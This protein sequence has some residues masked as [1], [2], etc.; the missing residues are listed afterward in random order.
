MPGLFSSLLGGLGANSPSPAGGLGGG[1]LFGMDREA[2]GM[3]GAGMMNRNMAGGMM[4]A[5]KFQ[6]M[7]RQQNMTAKL[8]LNRGIA[9][10]EE[11]ALAMAQQPALINALKGDTNA[12]AERAEAA[13]QYGLTG[14]EATSFVL[15]GQLPS[16]RFGSAEVGLSPIWGQDAEG[17]YVL[18]QPSKS[19]DMVPSRMPDGVKPLSPYDKSFQTSSGQVAGKG[20]GEALSEWRSMSSKMPSVEQVVR[21]LDALA[22]K[23]TYTYLGQGRDWL[24]RQSGY[25]ATEGATAR[26]EYIAKVDNQILPMLRDTFGA[27]FTVAE[28]QQLRSTLGDPDKSEQEKQVVLKAFIE[29][30]RRDIEAKARQASGDDPSTIPAPDGGGEDPLGIR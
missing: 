12:F 20:Q 7:R 3:L 1:G 29:Q 14:D 28:G 25:G 2:L 8:L 22:E 23:A 13:R 6:G 30:K 19:G 5:L 10:S 16:G 15:T 27:Q 17:N 18:M 24:A 11:E 9:K 26:A 4:E 21:E